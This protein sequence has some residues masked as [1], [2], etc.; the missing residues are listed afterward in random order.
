MARQFFA[1]LAAQDQW[2]VLLT[3]VQPE[4]A[5]LAEGGLLV[6][7]PQSPA[8]W[9]RDIGLTLVDAADLMDEAVTE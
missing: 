3:A 9:L 8:E 4:M 5:I 1:R 7:G 6:S 2:R